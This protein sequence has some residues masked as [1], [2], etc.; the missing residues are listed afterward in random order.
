M[1]E[2]FVWIQQN[3]VHDCIVPVVVSVVCFFV[4]SKIKSRDEKRKKAPLIYI[5]KL[6]GKNKTKLNEEKIRKCKHI[7][8]LS[9]K[10]YIDPD[11][12]VPTERKMV[13]RE[14]TYRELKE[15]V[16]KQPLIIAGFENIT[17]PGLS[18]SYI[19]SRQGG[20]FQI[21][22]DIVP[23]LID[24][25]TNY[26]IVSKV[27]DFPA[28]LKGKYLEHPVQYQSKGHDCVLRPKLKKQ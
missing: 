7:I 22:E 28:S 3:F 25:D 14:I 1:R 21:D 9:Y 10:I 2:C 27:E 11:H 20:L 15:S 19:T 5:L 13:F 6:T 4:Q 12:K 8:E 26:C 24:A 17:E 23:T 18:L 16:C